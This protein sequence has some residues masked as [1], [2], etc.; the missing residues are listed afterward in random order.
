MVDGADALDEYDAVQSRLDWAY[1]VELNSGYSVGAALKKLD[2]ERRQLQC[3]IAVDSLNEM[4]HSLELYNAALALLTNIQDA[5]LLDTVGQPA[6]DLAARLFEVPADL[7]KKLEQVG[8]EVLSFAPDIEF[9]SSPDVGYIY[10]PELHLAV[11]NAGTLQ[12]HIVNATTVLHETLMKVGAYAADPARV[13][14]YMGHKSA[15]FECTEPYSVRVFES[16]QSQ[17]TP[18][19]SAGLENTYLTLQECLHDY[20]TT[21]GNVVKINF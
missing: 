15:N 13:Y 2:V 3:R 10:K 5:Q 21:F 1:D 6:A 11:T 8:L 18:P 4:P 9:D 17:L 16:G 20:V 12:T 19:E 14:L 7:T